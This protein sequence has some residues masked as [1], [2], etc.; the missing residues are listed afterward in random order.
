M[1]NANLPVRVNAVL[2][3]SALM[4]FTEVKEMME[5]ELSTIL[6]SILDLMNQIDL[7]YL[8]LALKEITLEFTDKIGPYAIDLVKSLAQNFKKYKQNAYKKA[9]EH[10]G[11]ILLMD[12]DCS[13]SNLA[14]E[15]CLDAINNILRV[16]LQNEVYYEVGPTIMEIFDLSILS[17]SPT[18]LE[19]SLSY[20]NIVINKSVGALSDDTIFYFPVLCYL[21]IGF[22]HGGELVKLHGLVPEK[23]LELLK[24]LPPSQYPIF[25]PAYLLSPILNFL[26]KSSECNQFLENRDL[27]GVSFTDLLFKCIQTLG[28]NA[29]QTKNNIDLFLS[30]RM[31]MGFLENFR[32]QIDSFLPGILNI[33]IEVLKTER[34]PHLKGTLVGAFSIAILYNPRLFLEF[35][36]SKGHEAKTTFFSWY[37]TSIAELESD[38]DRERALYGLTSLLSLGDEQILDGLNPVK[39]INECVNLSTYLNNLKKEALDKNDTDDDQSDKEMEDVNVKDDAEYDPD[40]DDEDY[41]DEDYKPGDSV[42]D[43]YDDDYSAEN[44][45]SSYFFDKNLPYIE[46]I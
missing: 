22:P 8:V 43:V 33:L 25:N 19:K 7:N 46:F 37:Q 6:K 17:N 41:E 9:Q 16:Q 20:L 24:K 21:A 3:L 15:M 38:I 18:C 30:I 34:A 44:I 12:E 31:I 11:S 40:E 23:N 36:T 39:L 29:F 1:L 27:F 5:S 13:E 26:Q 32:G 14:S 45:V 28:D 42:E 2:A 35:W 10:T 4:E